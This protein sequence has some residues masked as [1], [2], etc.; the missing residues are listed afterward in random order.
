MYPE[1]ESM[2]RLLVAAGSSFALLAVVALPFAKPSHRIAAD[3]PPPSVFPTVAS[4]APTRPPVA[5]APAPKPKPRIVAR[6]AASRSRRVVSAPR[7]VR[8]AS[9]VVAESGAESQMISWTN[10]V[11]ANAGCGSVS[12]YGGLPSYARQ[13]SENMASSGELY[14]SSQQQLYAACPSCQW[15]GEIVGAG[16][17]IQSVE[18]G[19]QNS[20]THYAAITN[21][22]YRWIGA[23]VVYANGNYWVTE[24]FGG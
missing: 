23:G 4:A 21:G 15:V 24:F 7:V 8:H 22:N 13:H 5:K 3:P 11:R 14:H 10:G 2:K 17:T 1:G 19:F 20:S 12:A 6:P 16:P 9:P 18:Q